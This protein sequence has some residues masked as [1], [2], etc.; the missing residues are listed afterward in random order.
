L[1][2]GADHMIVDHIFSH[3]ALT[4]LSQNCRRVGFDG[5]KGTAAPTRPMGYDLTRGRLWIPNT[6]SPHN[7]RP[8]VGRGEPTKDRSGSAFL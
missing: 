7:R 4:R 6:D 3:S 1:G 2:I 8:R 5:L